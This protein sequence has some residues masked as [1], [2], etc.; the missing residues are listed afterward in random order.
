MR[1]ENILRANARLEKWNSM[2]LDYNSYY[3]KNFNTLKKRTRKGIPDCLR[4][5]VWQIF[6]EIC[7]Y[8]D[9][10]TFKD[11]YY[12][13]V[14]DEISDEKTENTILRDIERTFPKHFYFSEK[15]GMGQ[16]S[17]Y[18]VLRSYAKFNEAT[19]YVQGMGFLAAIM[20]TYMDEE[21]TFWM[22]HSLM[23]K[24]NMKGY[25][26][27]GFP[28]LNRSFYKLLCLMKKHLNKIYEKFKANNVYPSM[29]ACQWFISLF[30]VNFKFDIL[31]RIFDVFLLEGEKIFYRIALA[32]L[33][34]NE[35]NILNKSCFEY[36]MAEVKNYYENIDVDKLLKVAF[37]FSISRTHLAVRIYNLGL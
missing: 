20:L 31:V 16:R 34:L 6:G 17:L 15:Y 11:L 35:C 33:K 10:Y 24:Y 27:N 3:K 7:K 28:E 12:T 9:D 37:G 23:L 21:S 29:Y 5:Q 1:K 13:F 22:I 8:R 18:N 4:G 36:I 2:L 19:G 32:I 30:S 14:N 25:Y 26:M